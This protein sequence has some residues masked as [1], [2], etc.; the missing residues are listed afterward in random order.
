MKAEEVRI[1]LIRQT[2]AIRKALYHIECMLGYYERLVEEELRE[3]EKTQKENGG[4]EN[5]TRNP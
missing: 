1:S 2:Q 5:P 4:Q 3:K